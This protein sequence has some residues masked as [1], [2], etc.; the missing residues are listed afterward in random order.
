MTSSTMKPT[1]L[2]ERVVDVFLS[3]TKKKCFIVTYS[4]FTLSC[5]LTYLKMSTNSEERLTKGNKYT[6]PEKEPPV[7]LYYEQHVTNWFPVFNLSGT[8]PDY[9]I[10]TNDLRL[11]RKSKVV[12][13]FR[14][15]RKSP[16]VK[17]KDQIWLYLTFE[18][19][20]RTRTP[21]IRWK[22]SIKHFDGIMSYRPNSEVLVP[23]GRIRKLPNA[24]N[25]NVN[26]S[27]IYARKNM[28]VAW[29][30][31]HCGTQSKREAYVNE[32]RKYINVDV[33]GSCGNK[34]CPTPSGRVIKQVDALTNCKTDIS[35]RY[36]FYL[37]FEN[38]LCEHYS[39]E[40][41]FGIYDRNNFMIPVVRG[42]PKASRYLPKG[43]YIST[44][45]YASPKALAEYL[46]YIG[47]SEERYTRYLK[48]KLKYNVTIW[49]E[50]FVDSICDLCTKLKSNSINLNPSKNFNLLSRLKEDKCFNPLDVKQRH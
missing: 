37:A 38:T 13:F 26:Y 42:D 30:V 36:K 48:E 27:S 23:F 21:Q 35:K 20:L 2:K 9:C 12:I 11:Y 39:S 3:V 50:H 34:R 10:F 17:L 14:T 28:E 32:M 16:P 25:N 19:P 5:V 15:L 31:S 18:S 22:D 45:D 24:Y 49:T 8:C 29:L 7:I 40:K 41:V 46:H 47:S 43:T 44:F 6:I 33:F 1:G 4:F